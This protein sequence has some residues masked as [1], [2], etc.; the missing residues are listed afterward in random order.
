MTFSWLARK[1]QWHLQDG[2][3]PLPQGS[4]SSS[5]PTWSANPIFE[6]SG[7]QIQL[8]KQSM[9]IEL[10]VWLLIAL[11][12]YFVFPYDFHAAKTFDSLDWVYYRW[13]CV[14]CKLCHIFSQKFQKSLEGLPLT[15]GSRL[16]SSG[17][18]IAPSTCLDG[19]SARSYPTD[20]T[21]SP[22]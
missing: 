5:A 9:T 10:K 4:S 17:S 21:G 15:S 13:N 6:N 18:G 12:D 7:L 22:R 11:V 3:F 8:T 20:G 2:G 16:D 1:L 14:A 19:Q